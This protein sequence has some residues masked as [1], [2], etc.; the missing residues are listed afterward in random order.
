MNAGS[1]AAGSVDRQIG[2]LM[3]A[4]RAARGLSLRDVARAMDVSDTQIAKYEAGTNR[5]PASRLW[6]IASALDVS[7]QTLFPAA[8]E[9]PPSDRH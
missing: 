6:R 9:P 2:A 3:R 8:E 4:A 1:R 5:V 7:I